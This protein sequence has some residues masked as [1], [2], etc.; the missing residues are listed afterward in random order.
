MLEPRNSLRSEFAGALLSA[1]IVSFNYVSVR[2]ATGIF[3]GVALSRF[4]RAAGGLAGYSAV[5]LK[6]K[7]PLP[8]IGTL[9][10]AMLAPTYDKTL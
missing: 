2:F 9:L 8:N 5:E 3:T 7:Q 1:D 4:P 6:R 10:F